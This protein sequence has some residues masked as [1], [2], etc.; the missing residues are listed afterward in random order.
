MSSKNWL[1]WA[2]LAFPSSAACLTPPQGPPNP[3]LKPSSSPQAH[4]AIAFLGAHFS[5]AYGTLPASSPPFYLATPTHASVLSFLLSLILLANL[6]W[7]LA[8]C[9][10]LCQIYGMHFTECSHELCELNTLIIP[11]LKLMKLR[12]REIR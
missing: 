12:P 2:L 3:W 8:I 1:S 10:T 7:V 6:S 9:Q 5:L 11:V 4:Y